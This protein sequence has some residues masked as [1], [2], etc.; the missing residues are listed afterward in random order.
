MFLDQRNGIESVPLLH[1]VTASGPFRVQRNRVGAP[2]TAGLHL[3]SRISSIVGTAGPGRPLRTPTHQLPPTRNGNRRVRRCI[4]CTPSRAPHPRPRTHR[5][6][7]SPPA[8]PSGTQNLHDHSSRPDR[9][10]CVRPVPVRPD[11]LRLQKRKAICV[12]GRFVQLVPVHDGPIHVE[13]RC[14]HIV[15]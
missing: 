2:R 4:R 6:I 3:R 1:A 7:P 13:A 14:E 15:G 5:I 11:A 8:C 9:G 12:Y 10:P